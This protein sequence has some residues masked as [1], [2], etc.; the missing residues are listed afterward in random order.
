MATSE[1]VQLNPHLTG[2][3]CIRCSRRYPVGDYPEGCS[4]CLAE[5]HPASL[6]PVFSRDREAIDGQGSGSGMARF[7]NRLGYKRFISLGEGDTPLVSLPGLAKLLGMDRIYAKLEGSNPT[8]SHKD[9][10]SA[11]FVARALDRG[12]PA[13]IAAT[14]G[15][16]GASLAAYAGA[17]GLPCTIVT[18]P[19]IT[20]PWRRAIE[21]AGANIIYTQ[22]TP[23]RWV[24]V[25]RKVLE[26]GFA[27]A[28]NYLDP[29]VGSDAWGVDG[30]KTLG[31]ELAERQQETNADVV[32]VPTARGDLLWGIF[33]GFAESVEEGFCPRAPQLVAV[34]PFPRITRVMEG[35]DLREHFP[36]RNAMSSIAGATV[37]LQSVE[38]LRKSNGIA[39]AVTEEEAI[40]DQKVLAST[41]G[42]YTELSAAATLSALRRVLANDPTIRSAILVLTSHGYKET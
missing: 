19:A 18:T 39:V 14:S 28:T 33:R 2:L 34:E 35:A 3:D 40:A 5:G 6:E 29:P 22:D 24:I 38:A 31:Y 27:S 30:Y 32:I 4:H 25:R 16:A 37:T 23:E 7:A 41:G 42:Q 12:A 8:G 36:G 11:Q 15:N 1:D 9:R 10:M 21:M 17:A 13:V 20:A 26:E